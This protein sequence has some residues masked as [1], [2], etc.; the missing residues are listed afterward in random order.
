M[1]YH[2]PDDPLVRQRILLTY[3]AS[4][5]K[6]PTSSS[7]S[8]AAPAAKKPPP[9]KPGHANNSPPYPSH[10]TLAWDLQVPATNSQSHSS[11]PVPGSQGDQP[12]IALG[13]GFLS[14][15]KHTP[16]PSH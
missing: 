10:G 3:S 2:M 8:P 4:D 12:H 5:H 13:H 16:G 14:H 9:N 11:H 15:T 6:P 1:L 7:Q